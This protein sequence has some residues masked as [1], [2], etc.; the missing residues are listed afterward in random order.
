MQVPASTVPIHAVLP[1]GL[2]GCACRALAPYGVRAYI[3]QRGGARSGVALA[4]R[5]APFFLFFFMSD[6]TIKNYLVRQQLK[7]NQK[8]CRR[9]PAFSA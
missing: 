3:Q 8:L 6:Q 5:H 7:K 2:H 4:R 9:A 1:R